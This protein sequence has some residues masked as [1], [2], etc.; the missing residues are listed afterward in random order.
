MAGGLAWRGGDVTVRMVPTIFSGA[1]NLPTSLT[2]TL[3]A[4]G[5]GVIEN[6]TCSTIVAG[7]C[8]APTE[9]ATDAT[10]EAD[11]SFTVTFSGTPAANGS[12]TFGSSAATPGVSRIEDPFVTATIGGQVASGNPYIGAVAVNMGGAP[13]VG[14]PVTGANILRLDNLAPRVTLLDL[15][16]AFLGCAPS[17]SCYV[18]GDFQFAAS[19]NSTSSSFARTVDLG[20]DAQT[21]SFQAGPTAATLT[22]VTNGGQLPETQVAQTNVLALTTVDALQNARTV[23]ATDVNTCVSHSS[24]S[25]SAANQQTGAGSC[26]GVTAIQKFGIDLTPP[27]M[28]VAGPPNNGANDG[29]VYTFSFIDVGGSSTAGP[30]GFSANPVMVKVERIT[31]AGTTCFGDA[32]AANATCAFVSDEGTVTLPANQAYYRVTASVVDQA[33]NVSTTIT[34]ITLID[35]TAPVVGG[36]VAPSIISGG[37][38]V[39][40]TASSTDNVEL[41]D[42][43]AAIAY[44]GLVTLGFDRRLLA[45]YG[46]D[47]ILNSTNI[48]YTID[49]F[50]HSIETTNGAGRPTGAIQTATG[51]EFDVRDMAGLV[52]NIACPPAAASFCGVTNQSLVANVSAQGS[53]WTTINPTFA[54]ANPLHGNFLQQAPS[55]AVVC[56]GPTGAACSPSNQPT[57]TVL[58]AT[59]TGQNTT[60][61]NPF[62][63]VVFYYIDSMGRAQVIGTGTAS[64]S[65]NTITSTRTWT[66]TTTWN[67]NGFTP[68]GAYQVFVLGIDG[69]GRALMS[70]Q[71]MVTIEDA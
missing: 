57:S 46:P 9:S 18:N 59:V 58:S 4:S 8:G 28:T 69:N 39:T 13:L 1:G 51:A 36:I 56:N 33:G 35:T 15:T 22:S 71:Q 55:V 67:V 31:A 23:Y 29:T 62:A 7:G 26:A 48:S 6:G 32:G 37:G 24:T 53:S 3:Q 66:Y 16:P 70:N 63:R 42:V 5:G 38:P 44:G 14:G 25:V 17:S 40:L 45:D 11:G 41:G 52:D 68:V 50:I 64:A 60:F 43:T 10:R 34:R 2:V 49:Q 20:V 54:S 61:A 21:T 47:A 30:S 12:T 19:N 27:T 65:D